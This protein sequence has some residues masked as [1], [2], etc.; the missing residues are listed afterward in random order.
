MAFLLG[1]PNK[2]RASKKE[3]EIELKIPS[4][5]NENLN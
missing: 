1:F 3:F 4:S 5:Y 2:K